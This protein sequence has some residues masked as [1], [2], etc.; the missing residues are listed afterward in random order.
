MSPR[1]T[2]TSKIIPRTRERYLNATG[3]HTRFVELAAA[4]DKAL[5]AVVAHEATLTSK[6]SAL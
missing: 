2:L 5:A 4:W 6:W 1:A 3:R